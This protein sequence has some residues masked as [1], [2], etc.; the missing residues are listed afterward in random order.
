M[1]NP[2]TCRRSQPASVESAVPSDHYVDAVTGDELHLAWGVMDTCPALGQ[3]AE[4]AA[5]AGGQ[6][7]EVVDGDE[8]PPT[9]LAEP[10]ARLHLDLR[11]VLPVDDDESAAPEQ[12]VVA[13]PPTEASTASS[14]VG[15]VCGTAC[16]MSSSRSSSHDGTAVGSAGARRVVGPRPKAMIRAAG[17]ARFPGGR[18]D[19]AAA[20]A[21]HRRPAARATP[22][23]LRRLLPGSAIGP[24]PGLRSRPM[25]LTICRLVFIKFGL[26]LPKGRL[27]HRERR[28]L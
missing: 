20:R 24:V 1:V 8:E 5:R 6:R 28:R 16:T 9:V 22:A 15:P 2:D 26:S 25:D 7:G 18:D 21:R 19:C 10:L 13:V 14:A 4:L 17:T 3:H 12:V 11:R 27:Q 23:G